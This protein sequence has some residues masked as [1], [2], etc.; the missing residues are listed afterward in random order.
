VRSVIAAAWVAFRRVNAIGQLSQKLFTVRTLAETGMLRPTRP[1]KALRLANALRRWGPTP[2]AGYTM[3]AIRHPDETAIIDELGTLTFGEVHRRTNALAHALSDAGIGEGDGVAM[4][5]RNHR[6]FVD[7]TVACS[8]LGAHSLYLN[9]AFAGP[10][11]TEVVKREKPVALIYDAEFEAIT[12]DAGERRKRF[13]AWHDGAEKPKDPLLEDLIEAGDPDDVV[14]PENKGRVVILTSGTTGSPK[15]AQRKQPESLDPAAALF[16]KIPLRAR[17]NTM[18]AAP[19][20]HSWGFVHFTLGMGL[21][22]TIVLRRKFDPE[23]TLSATAQHECTTLVVVPVMLSRILELPAETID[24]YDLSALRVIAASGSALPGELAVKVMDRFGD[25]LYNLYGSTEVAWATIATPEDLRAAPGTAGRPPR[26]TIVKLLDEEGNEV[27]EGETGRIFVG[28]EMAFEGYTGGGN[29]QNVG[30]LLSS[31]DV[32]HFDPDGRLFIDGR[33]DEMI[34]SG[35][36]NV[37]PREIEDLLADHDAVDEVAV[38]GVDDEQF[39]QRLKAFV[40]RTSGA[41]AGEDEL[42]D[43]VKANLARYKVPREISFLDEL[44]RNATGKVVKRDLAEHE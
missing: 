35:G 31:G 6:G 24:M 11:I 40:V 34:V 23:D 43:Y 44:P 41:T 3:S 13:I 29:K 42:K 32:G 20:F 21:G 5:I 1:D 33:D 12:H 26:G 8:K 7:A 28:N 18:I 38:I 16:S 30:G 15:G 17:E 27:G 37:F 22:S 14:P 10:Q 4:M 36:E 2:A 19:M 39:G 9:T 25:V